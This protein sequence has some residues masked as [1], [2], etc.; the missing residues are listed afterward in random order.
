M[1]AYAW[2]LVWAVVIAVVAVLAVRE[3][4][5]GR[6]VT[7]DVDRFKHEAHREA[8][9]REDLRGPGTFTDFGG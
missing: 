9:V 5:A 6:R 8:G 3:R 2:I 4:R 7:A 1:P